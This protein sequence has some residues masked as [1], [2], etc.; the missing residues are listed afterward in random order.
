MKKNIKKQKIGA[1]GFEVCGFEIL[2]N[3]SLDLEWA[4]IKFIELGE[5]VSL[6]SFDGVIIPNGIFEEF[7]ETHNVM[8]SSVDVRFRKEIL[9]QRERELINLLGKNGWVCSLIDTI[10]DSVPRG[11]QRAQCNDTDL[12]KRILNNFNVN[13]TV[14]K[15]SGIVTPLNDEFRRY[16]QR[17]GVAKTM[18]GFRHGFNKHKNL[19]KVGDRTVGFEISGKF[20]FLPFHTTDFG[21]DNLK[22]LI[23]DLC[24]AIHNYSLKRITQIPHWVN[25]FKFNE[26]DLLNSKLEEHLKKAEEIQ[27]EI[28]GI[29]S[30]KGIATQSG[31]SLKDN[32]VLILR[33]FFELNVTDIEDFKED[34]LIKDDGGNPIVVIEVKGTNGGIKRKYIN[35]LDTNRERINISAHTP[36]LLIIN[37][38]MNT[39]GFEKRLNTTVSEE[40]IKH[41]HNLNILIIRT[42]EMLYIMRILKTGKNIKN[43]FLKYVFSG[44]GIL[45]YIDEKVEH[46]T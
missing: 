37:D 3:D 43:N 4:I 28:T 24:N 7:K 22:K 5:N 16:I 42:I 14:F 15:G 44:G 39:E 11:L 9:L 38:Q 36:G 18:F 40:H 26:E 45:R 12:V 32:V 30:F 23:K 20:Y 2:D 27:N 21:N 31:D 41:A 8:G 25:Q 13:R 46:I 17:W 1:L 33:D 6:D 35:Q 19:A 10:I 29:Q 34:A